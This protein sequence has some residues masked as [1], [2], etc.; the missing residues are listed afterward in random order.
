VT[1]KKGALITSVQDGTPGAGK[2]K[3]LDVVIRADSKDI[4]DPEDL[5]QAVNDKSEGSLTLKVIR[6]KKEITVVVTLPAPPAD[7][8]KG[9]KL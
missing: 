5:I 2:L 9:I 7:E 6:D 8:E 4:K 3:L 1:G